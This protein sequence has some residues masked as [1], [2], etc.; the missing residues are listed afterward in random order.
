M[1]TIKIIRK[2]C[3]ALVCAELISLQ[4][5]AQSG[6]F[7]KAL[8]KG[9]YATALEA[10]RPLAEQGDPTAQVN[11]GALYRNGWGVPE[12]IVQAFYWELKAAQQGNMLG[13]SKVGHSY[14]NGMGIPQDFSKAVYW[15][16][17]AAEQGER[18]AL[19]NLGVMYLD[20]QGVKQSYFSA[21]V[22]FNL[23]ASGGNSQATKNRDDAAAKLSP[24]QLREAQ[25]RSANWTPE[26]SLPIQ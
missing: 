17:K 6:E 2:I 11:L 21:Y 9:D 5:I 7:F 25:R 8:N 24:K 12:D 15:Y 3:V 13:Q 14:A 26:T 22:L 23:A 1:V 16:Q 4:A 20:G 10:V 18:I 19:N